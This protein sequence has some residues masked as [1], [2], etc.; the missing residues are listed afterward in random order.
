M[1]KHVDHG[2]GKPLLLVHGLGSS[3][4]AWE[5]I[6]EPLAQARRV[7]VIDL[8]GHGAT[9]AEADSGTFDG[10][11]RS[12]AAW[13]N[14]TGMTGVDMV[15]SS[16]GARLVLEL[17]RRGLAGN[18]V[19][20]DPGGFWEG[21][22]RK[23]L[24]S[25]LTASRGLVKGLRSALPTLAANRVSRSAL[26]AQLSAR[27]W[28]LDGAFVAEELRALADTATVPSLVKD[29]GYGPGQEGIAQTRGRLA[30]GWGRHD[31]LCLPVQAKRAASKFPSAK[32]HWFEHSGHFP[33]WDEPR[34]T[35]KLI[36]E[37]C[38]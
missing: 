20:L 2:R 32:L 10:L 6:I 17:A 18:V 27:P 4:H 11:V 16:M 23:W 22:E 35:V 29:L 34:E 21:W 38:G 5:P 14:E 15:G 9:P 3:G 25:T 12:V 13:L 19:A 7:M 37:V 1:M 31:R 30:I 8:P 33:L 26:L 24:V 36:A 28:A